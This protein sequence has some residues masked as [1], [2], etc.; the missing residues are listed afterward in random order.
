MLNEL[1]LVAD[2]LERLG[3]VVTPRHSRINPMGKNR[4]LLIVALDNDG[5]P[6]RVEV[7]SG[8]IA[9]DLFRFEHRSKGSSFP[10]FNVPTPLRRLDDA[11]VMELTVVVEK[12]LT[13]GKNKNS[14]I[15]ELVEAFRALFRLSKP[16]SFAK[17]Q[18]K[19]FLRSCDE[20]VEE[21]AKKLPPEPCELKN[22]RTLIQTVLKSKPKLPSFAESLAALFASQNSD[23]DRRMVLL[24]Q[25]ILFGTLDWKKRTAAIGS[26]DYW[27]EKRKQ[28]KPEKKAKQPVY[29][30]LASPDAAYARVAHRK[31][32][33]LINAALLNAPPKNNENESGADQAPSAEDAFGEIAVLQDKFPD[34]PKVAKLGNIKLFSVNTNEVQALQ[35]YRFKGSQSFPVSSAR[36]QKMSDALFHLAND[37]KL[38]IT[39]RAIPSAQP[40]KRDLLV[41]YLEG[42]PE[43]RA[44]LA[45]MFGGEANSLSDADFAAIAQPVLEMLEGK[46]GAN[47][48][49]N[50]RLLAFCPIDKAKKQISLNRSLRV[51]DV[52][53]AARDWE[54]GARN[55]PQVSVWFYDKNTEQSVFRSHTA[56]CPL[57]IASTINWVWSTKADGGFTGKYQRAVSV[58]DAY[59]VFLADSQLS[60]AKAEAALRLLIARMSTVLA[61]VANIKHRQEW[62]R[63]NKITLSDV[64]RWQ[65]VKT[66]A[67]LGILLHQLG[68]YK[69]DFM[70]EPI[71][72]VG[73]LL[74]LADSLHL[75]YCKH[76]RDGKS[77]SQLIGNALFNTALEQPVFALARLAERLTPYQAW[78]RTF[79]SND[80]EAGVGLVKYF[81]GEIAA[82]TAAIRLDEL[83]QRMTDTDKA[84]LLLGYLADHPKTETPK[85]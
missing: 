38:G 48:N 18:E 65:S 31:T 36:V 12:L 58:A 81:L 79:Q 14:N 61:T 11:P 29:L 9:A 60:Q 52:I 63:K 68:H 56:P 25:D 46:V 32:S 84:K 13:L 51:R 47:P 85:Q 5:I 28:D 75:Q 67:L 76:I 49:L 41:A 10:G 33:A 37:D 82:C 19:Q 43:G 66:I 77:P 1:S 45:E 15:G 17:S 53:R 62:T 34:G 78:A 72:Q 7:L 35:R 2:S 80:P 21:L 59:D 71:T 57:E 30:D 83:P 64:V 24:F 42:E 20:L 16:Q 3:T 54:A 74:A 73:R 39:C 50:V 44:Q 69:K 23:F 8:E 27:K 40:D 22:F 26:P 55:V 4:D 6:S 70:Q